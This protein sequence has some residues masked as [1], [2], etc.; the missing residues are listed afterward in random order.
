MRSLNLRVIVVLLLAFGPG[1]FFGHAQADEPP[2]FGV[3]A[4]VQYGDLDTQGARHYRTAREKLEQCAADLADRDLAF[5][6]QLGDIVN[7]HGKDVEKCFTLPLRN[8]ERAGL[9]SES[10]V[11]KQDSLI[12]QRVC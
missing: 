1:F 9:P 7:G 11:L 2:A 10:S 3:M 5:V 6:I 12:L 4:D 8:R